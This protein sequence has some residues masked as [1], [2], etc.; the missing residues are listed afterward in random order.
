MN[1]GYH[2]GNLRAAVLE[3]VAVVIAERGPYGFSLRSLAADLGVSHTAPRH[4]FGSREGVLNALAAQ[5]FG[6]LAEALGQTRE[7]GGT[8]LD[9][10]VTYVEFAVGHPAHFQVMFTP[11]L[12]D[13]AHPE[14]SASRSRAFAELTGGVAELVR[15][16][17]TDDAA[18]A[19]IAGWSLVHGLATLAMTGNLDTAGVRA[20]LA[21][22]DL[23]E[24]ARR[25]GRMLF[26]SAARPRSESDVEHG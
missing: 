3:R 5:G 7:A 20:L 24:I 25:T 21:E 8:F 14:L 10:G 23:S 4:H 26:G 22:Q 19:L 9:L 17:R 11:A 12:L 18:A 15:D 13:E 6:W 2:H 16:N 1:D